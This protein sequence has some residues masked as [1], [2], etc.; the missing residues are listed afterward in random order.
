MLDSPFEDPYSADFGSECISF[1][2]SFDIN[3]APLLA[4]IEASLAQP[5]ALPLTFALQTS[6][7]LVKNRLKS[8]FSIFLCLH[9]LHFQ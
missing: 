9:F 3:P 7:L 4:I 1:H 8:H 6:A 2:A 5:R